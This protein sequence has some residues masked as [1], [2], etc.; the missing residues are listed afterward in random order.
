MIGTHTTIMYRGNQRALCHT[1]ELGVQA[2]IL[3]KPWASKS[4]RYQAEEFRTLMI[5]HPGLCVLWDRAC[6]EPHLHNWMKCLKSWTRG[7]KQRSHGHGISSD[8]IRPG[9]VFLSRTWQMRGMKSLTL[10]P[11]PSH[12]S[13][14]HEKNMDHL[15]SPSVASDQAAHV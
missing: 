2:Q 1:Q 14:G 3:G 8:Q 6:I 15:T 11:A 9:K 5:D 13:L 12:L 10:C 4:Q 7:L